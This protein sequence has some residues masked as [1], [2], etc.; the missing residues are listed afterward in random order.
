MCVCS[1]SYQACEGH[2]PYYIVICPL[3]GSTIFSTLSHSL[4]APFSWEKNVTEH[5]MCALT[6]TPTFAETFL[7]LGRIQRDIIKVN[8]SSCEVPVI[9]AGFQT[10]IFS[11]YF[12]K[13]THIS[14][15]MKILQV[16]AE[17]F[18]ADRHDEDNNRFSQY[19]EQAYNCTFCP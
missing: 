3:S 4:T 2:A 12:R 14:C 1:L 18:H 17:L 6:F 11:P 8:M 19:C 5:K 10:R 16:A 13:K 15:S 9:L 7:I